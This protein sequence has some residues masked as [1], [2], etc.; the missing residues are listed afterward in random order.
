MKINKI[1]VVLTLFSIVLIGLLLYSDNLIGSNPKNTIKE[2][3]NE[4]VGLYERREEIDEIFQVDLDGDFDENGFQSGDEEKLHE[5]L[6][7]I[8]PFFTEKSYKKSLVNRRIFSNELIEGQYSK[9]E[10]DILQWLEKEKEDDKAIYIVEYGEVF[11]EEDVAH[12]VIQI[13]E[14]FILEKIENQWKIS[15][16]TPKSN[17]VF[18]EPSN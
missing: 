14:E 8:R 10:L 17:K 6:I 4:K 12:R 2:Y 16:I 13:T 1:T 5:L 9:V 3:L 15:K 7:H 18:L 11:Y